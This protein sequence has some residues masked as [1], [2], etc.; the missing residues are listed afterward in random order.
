MALARELAVAPILAAEWTVERSKDA[1]EEW[2]TCIEDTFM[3]LRDEYLATALYYGD[4]DF[5]YQCWEK[6]IEPRD[7]Y[8]KITRLKQLL[9]DITEIC[10]GHK[11]GFI[12]VRQLGKD[13]GLA[14]SIHVGFRVEGSYLYGIPL[15]ENVRQIYN[16]WTDCNE[17]ARRYDRKIAGCHIV[18]EYP[19]GT[20][21]NRQGKEVECAVMAAEI[22]DTL[23]SAGG[24]SV[25]R[26]MAAYMQ[27]LNTDNP[28]WKIWILDAGGNQ[29]TSFAA[30][31]EY[32]DK[33]FCRGIHIPE[34]AM[35]EGRHGTLAEAEAHGDVI[36]TIQDIKHRRVTDELNRQ[37]VNQVLY[38]NYGRKAVGKVRLKASPIADQK[39]QYFADLYKALLGSPA[40]AQELG[41]LDLASIRDQLG[42]P[43]VVQDQGDLDQQGQP[44]LQAVPGV[45]AGVP[46]GPGKR[47]MAQGPVGRPVT[48]DGQSPNPAAELANAISGMRE[49][50]ALSST[51]LK[52]AEAA[53]LRAAIE[54]AAFSGGTLGDVLG[55]RGLAEQAEDI[56]GVHALPDDR[57]ASDWLQGRAVAGRTVEVAHSVAAANGGGEPLGMA[58]T[59]PV[60]QP[61]WE[62]EWA[63][64]PHSQLTKDIPLGD[65]SGGT[66]GRDF[67]HFSAYRLYRPEVQNESV[68]QEYGS[69]PSCERQFR[70]RPR[71]EHGY[72]GRGQGWQDHQPCRQGS[73]R[74]VHRASAAECAFH[75]HHAKPH[76]RLSPHARPLGWRGS[77]PRVQVSQEAG[78]RRRFSYCASRGRRRPILSQHARDPAAAGPPASAGG[79]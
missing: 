40:G 49:A 52:K 48:V 22:L 12:G 17:G 64:D 51:A 10:I 19:D 57:N 68:R 5:G 58:A 42:L 31:L 32:L 56:N 73:P 3:P 43:T 47:L 14:N 71:T 62:S 75:G 20:C 39:K 6:I 2:K 46:G 70:P 34:R 44:N 65:E 66:P 35:M 61:P 8:L 1:P 74:V 15:L 13:L 41:S 18:V 16:W 59:D 4:I 38:L 27:V 23:E 28:G 29:Q 69:R 72:Y 76:P 67:V 25:P 37:A 63:D 77:G 26:D 45:S 79:R 54:Q 53:E 78:F 33:Q 24:V 60:N 11:G 9:H 50:V 36:F 21:T 7:G 30:R 55:A